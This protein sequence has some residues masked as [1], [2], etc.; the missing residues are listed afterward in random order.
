MQGVVEFDPHDAGYLMTDG[1][2]I[3][4][5]VRGILRRVTFRM[6]SIAKQLLRQGVE[7]LQHWM[8]RDGLAKRL[9][10]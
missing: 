9:G 1:K 2:S 10:Q 4:T 5:W 3:K 8:Q 6:P 7:L